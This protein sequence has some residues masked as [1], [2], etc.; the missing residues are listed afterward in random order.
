MP[1]ISVPDSVIRKSQAL[2]F[3][4]RF[5]TLNMAPVSGNIVNR[6][7]NFD[8]MFVYSASR[9]TWTTQLGVDLEDTRSEMNYLLT[10]VRYKINLWKHVSVSPF[11][12]YYSEHAVQWVDPI[13]DANGGI[14]LSYQPGSLSVEAFAL[15]VRLTHEPEKKDLIYRFEVRYKL[16]TMQ[17]SVFVFHNTEY[18]DGKRRLAIGFRAVGPEFE[19][20]GKLKARTEVTGS[21]KVAEKPETTNL[22]GVFLS[23]AF[24][25]KS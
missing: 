2:V 7:V 18:Y 14:F 21:F 12:A 17:F 10:N 5:N 24:P 19:I 6:H 13:S 25:F 1:A 3:T 8:F 11:L 9:F 22:S 23:L 20:V 4:P 16:E 15:V